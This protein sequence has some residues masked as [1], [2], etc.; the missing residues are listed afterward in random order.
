MVTSTIDH[1]IQQPPASVFTR[2]GRFLIQYLRPQRG[3]VLWMA[4]LL[5]AGIGLQLLNP[6][7]IRYFLDTAQLGGSI[8]P[9]LLAAGIFILFA[10]LQQALQLAARLASQRVSWT[11]TNQLRLDLVQHCLH[12]DMP[13]HKEHTPGELIERIDGDADQLANF[14]SQ[15]VIRILSNLLLVLGILLLLFREDLLV[16]AGMA[17][18]TLLTLLVLGFFQR[19]AARRWAE[20]RQA[21]AEQFGYIEERISGAEELRAAGAEGYALQRLYRLMRSF[22]VKMRAAFV[23]SSLTWNL[24]N[25]IYVIG[26]A[27]GLALAV[28]LY[29][30]GQATL[31]TAYLIV[32]YVGMLT[33]PLQHILEQMQDLGQASASL[34]RVQELLN[35]QPLVNEPL[36]AAVHLPS[37]ALGVEFQDVAFHYDQDENVLQGVSF[38]L[39]PGQVLGILGR[40]GS[41]KSTLT[42]L[43]FRLY[44]PS[45]GK[46]HLGGTDLRR[47]ALAD[48][49]GRV[50]MVTQDVQLFEASVRDNLTFFDASIRDTQLE[51][52]L[53]S[54]RLWEWVQSLPQ[55]LETRLS[56]GSLGLSAGEAQLL[57]FGRVFLKDPGLVILDEASSRLD[58]VTE[59]LMEQAVDRLF[60]GRTAILIAHR[61]KTVQRADLILILENGKVSEFGPRLALAADPQSRF[62]HLLQTGLEEA[63]V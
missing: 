53:R 34:G 41:G 57:A 15:F 6:Q 11:A 59:A 3:R 52:V 42:R 25:L 32:Y 63:L 40:T 28:Y 45:Q 44:D 36:D 61:L 33:E 22:L 46:I 50:G 48:L 58:P 4:I 23:V 12:L 29:T 19:P 20:A 62:S 10:L 2:Y 49:R 51:D 56:T 14:F 47:V 55:G 5:L 54:L 16:G 35:L 24:S 26:Y 38:S 21:S 18:Y 13:F 27:A 8:Q 37:G 43:L 9:L 60:A 7:V 30:R 39:Q 1:S 31:G 17:L